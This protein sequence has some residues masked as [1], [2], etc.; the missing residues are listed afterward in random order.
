[1]IDRAIEAIFERNQDVLQKVV[2]DPSSGLVNLYYSACMDTGLIESDGTAVLDKLLSSVS[3][4][5]GLAYNLASLFQNGASALFEFG[6]EIDPADPT[7]NIYALNQGGLTLPDP[8]YYDDP[9]IFPQYVAHI[10][11]MLKLAG[12]NPSDADRIANFERTL[13]SVTVPDDQ[14]FDPFKSF[15]KMTWEQLYALSPNT[16]FRQ[17]ARYL[18]LRTNV[19]VTLDAPAFF[20][21]LSQVLASTPIETVTNYTRWRLIHWMA[22]RLPSAFVK[23]NF[24]FFGQILNGLPVQ[25]PRSKTCIQSTDNALPELVGRLFAERAFPATSKAAA[26]SIFDSIL[27]TFEG[28]VR[29]LDWM[30][31][32]TKGKAVHKLELILRL[33]GY[34]DHPRNY[35]SYAPEFGKHYAQNVLVTTRSEFQREMATAGGPSDRSQWEMSADTVNAYYSPTKNEIVRLLQNLS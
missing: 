31:P 28:K 1:M 17:F 18:Q 4:S 15:N 7:K 12:F 5:N 22:P 25:P 20:S 10:S 23:A 11:Q 16:Q 35:T 19:P 26:S 13:A 30:D 33:I 29:K 2:D 6:V 8:S 24:A 9:T 34:P 3:S 32:V 21:G 14:L 27:S